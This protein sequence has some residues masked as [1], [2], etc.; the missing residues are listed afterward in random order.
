MSSEALD[1]A[2]R[3]AQERDA[4]ALAA[5]LSDSTGL[6]T[7]AAQVA[8]RLRRI[9]GIELCVLAEVGGQVVGFASL[10]CLPCL[11]EEGPYAELVDLFV[12]AGSR[13]MGAA[14]AL[15]AALEARAR[16]AGAC[17][18]SVVVDPTNEAARSLYE[19]LGFATFAVAQ[20]KWFGSERPFRI[21]E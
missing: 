6:A 12:R 21:R 15:V 2:V 8:A 11:G 19:K 18:W 5:L 16:A 10:R 17:G 13:R 14:R 20:Q 3:E 4:P 1:I 7:S 9:R